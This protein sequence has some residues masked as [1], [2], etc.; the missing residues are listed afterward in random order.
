MA[1]IGGVS[2][3]FVHHRPGPSGLKERV[4]VWQSTGYDGYNAQKLGR[5]DSPFRFTAVK[6]GTNAALNTW[7]DNIEALAGS[8]ISI[9][10][11]FGD[12]YTDLLVNPLS[13]ARKTPAVQP[14]SGDNLRGEIL[15]QGVK[16]A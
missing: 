15:I 1:E 11:D 8:V 16:A 5:G 10:D 3:D 2:C 13:I 14:G 7:T 9:V 12:T 6:Y 4:H